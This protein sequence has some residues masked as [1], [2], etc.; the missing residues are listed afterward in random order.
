MGLRPLPGL[1]RRDGGT[2]PRPSP[3]RGLDRSLEVVRTGA[4]GA[5]TALRPL[6]TVARGLGRLAT[7]AR[8]WWEQAPQERRGPALCLAVVCLLV[9]RLVPYGPQG[10]A[11]AL[12]LA[13][14][15]WGRDGDGDPPEPEDTGPDEAQTARLQ[16][17]YEALVPYFAVPDDPHPE[18][19]YAHG[20]DWQRSF[21]EF[22]FTA[23]GRLARLTLRYPPCFRDGEAAQRA[24]VERLL[25]AK[26]G[27]GREYA[28]DWDEEQNLLSLRVV[29]PLPTDICAQPFVTAPG[30]TVLGFT[31]TD[32]V[33]RTLPV[34][35]ASGTRD[36]PPV[37][38]RTGPRSTEPHLLA[39][40]NP[41]SGVSTL[42][43]SLAAQALRYGDVLVVDGGGSGEFA[44]L[45]GRDGVLGVESSLTG[46]SAALEW[47]VH[48]TERRLLTA[49]RCRQAGEPV[50]ADVRR[51]LW[52]L[53][54]RPAVL[55]HMAGAEGRRDPQE[56][57]DVPL[58]HGRAANVTVVVAEQFEGAEGLT[59]AVRAYTRARV[60]L[61]AASPDQVRAILGE[62]PR[63]T[64]VPDPPPGRGYARLG[65]GPV[66]R[67]QVPAT[68]D[69]HDE[70]TGEAQRRAVLALLPERQ[71]ADVRVAGVRAGE[72]RTAGG[73]PAQAT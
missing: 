55:R 20:G 56:L 12:A 47:A 22:A 64:P 6:G 67:L 52:L 62:P 18:P 59:Q 73:A 23:S 37:L 14:F 30:E 17:L 50:P 44:C 8:G 68:P 38:W 54:E 7:A 60:V 10:A 19:L 72:V 49:S 29:A 34:T 11:V 33:P 36:V 45:V 58:R 63:T 71:R 26:A 15:W 16:T 9:V 51:P 28:F 39:L 35:D 2:P 13:A 4:G 43:R 32:A 53:V 24:P 5:R 69:P 27:R 66:L 46:A 31:D 42:L 41:G 70:A 40:G 48:E 57:L 25:G 65:G 21:E 3:R 61:G 1:L